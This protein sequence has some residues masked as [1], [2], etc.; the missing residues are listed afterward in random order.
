MKFA[1]S[2]VCVLLGL[3]PLVP[4]SATTVD[5]PD[6]ATLVKKAD[7]IFRGKVTAVRCAWVGEGNRRHIRSYVSFEVLKVLK[8]SPS[9][10][11]VM[12]MLG[13]TVDDETMAVAGA[14]AFKP[15]E[16]SLLFVQNNGTQFV[17]LVGI[18]HGRFPIMSDPVT[19]EDRVLKHDGSPLTGTDEIDRIH[20]RGPITTHDEPAPTDPSRS[21]GK[22]EPATVPPDKGLRV[23]EFEEQIVR[24]ATT[25]KSATQ[26]TTST[27]NEAAAKK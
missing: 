1:S 15:G 6:F 25:P 10:P 16:R 11:F 27:F 18:M 17:P 12:E 22:P 21:R 4:L 5:P 2:F 3:T 23:Q 8:G 13:G 14:P 7:V 24:E 9:T 19:G 20:A 26:T